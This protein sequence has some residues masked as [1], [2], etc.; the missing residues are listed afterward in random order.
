DAKISLLDRTSEAL[1]ATQ[2]REA[3]INGVSST[4]ILLVA[5][6]SLWI[7][8]VIAIPLVGQRVLTGPDFA[9]IGLFVLASFDAVSALPAAYNALG[10]TL[11]AA[12]RIFEVIDTSP[13]V[14]E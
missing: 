13:A 5:Q 14:R 6:L 11:A 4:L 3:R 12:R 8:L 9:M 2:R 1:I 7:S 10:Q